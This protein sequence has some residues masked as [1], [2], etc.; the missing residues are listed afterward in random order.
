M[1]VLHIDARPHPAE[2]DASPT[3]AATRYEPR[4]TRLGRRARNTGAKDLTFV[5][6]GTGF[7]LPAGESI[8]VNW[9]NGT[10]GEPIPV[11]DWYMIRPR[12]FDDPVESGTLDLP[13]CTPPTTTT[14]AT[15]P[16]TTVATTPTTTIGSG[17]GVPTTTAPVAL[18]E[19]GADTTMLALLASVMLMAGGAA[20][21]VARRTS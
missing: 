18:P 2:G 12:F 15:A 14:V 20:V 5:R 10:V 21:V 16:T 8:T 9:P 13:D 11:L 3:A 4:R 7:P 19:T 6:E 1:A 17:A